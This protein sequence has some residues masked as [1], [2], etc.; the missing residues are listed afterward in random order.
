[1]SSVLDSREHRLSQEGGMRSPEVIISNTESGNSQQVAKKE[2]KGVKKQKKKIVFTLTPSNTVYTP[3]Q[4]KE[5]KD[6]EK[7]LTNYIIE[8]LLN[9]KAPSI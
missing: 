2:K 9:Y 7:V 3:Q 6:K 1:M 8:N 5:F 4:L